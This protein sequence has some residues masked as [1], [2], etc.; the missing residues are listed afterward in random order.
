MTG[1]QPEDYAENMRQMMAAQEGFT[2]IKQGVGF[3][4]PMKREIPNFFYGEPQPEPVP[5]RAR[6]R[7]ADR[8]GPEA[9]HRL[10]RPR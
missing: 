6:P 2:I 3:H 9:R 7:P 1:Y 10:R 5:R 4:S 8:E